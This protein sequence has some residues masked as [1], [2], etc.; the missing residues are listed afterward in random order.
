MT[1]N[2]SPIRDEVLL[3]TDLDRFATEP[4]DVI[5]HDLRADVTLLDHR[6]RRRTISPHDAGRGVYLSILDAGQTRLLPLPAKVLHIGRGIDSDVRLADLR[7]SRSHAIIV[8][9]D[10][11]TRLIDNRSATGTFV[12]GRRV[13][14]T[15]LQDGDVIELGPVPMRFLELD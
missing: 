3:G 13:Q 2:L 14:A 8:R 1:T 4:L 9:H 15:N 11:G 7:V 5:D 6:T 12:N 10:H